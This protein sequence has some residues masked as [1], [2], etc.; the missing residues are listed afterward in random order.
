VGTWSP[1]TLWRPPGWTQDTD[2]PGLVGATRWFPIVTW[3]Q[4]TADLMAGFSAVPGFGH[5]Y[6]NAFVEAWAAV[7][8]PEG[9]T[10][11]DTERVNQL[12]GTTDG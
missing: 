1:S 2:A 4:E 11:E 6:S 7:V 10:A 9:W 8:P 3:V 5:D 12:L